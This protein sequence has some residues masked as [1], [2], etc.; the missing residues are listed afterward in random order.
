MYHLLLSAFSLANDVLPQLDAHT[1]QHHSKQTHG[2]Q[3]D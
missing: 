1:Q 2:I 3:Q